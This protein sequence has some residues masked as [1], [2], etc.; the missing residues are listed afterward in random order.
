MIILNKKVEKKNN[1]IKLQSDSFCINK[2]KEFTILDLEQWDLFK[3]SKK[4]LSN[5]GIKVFS[6][7]TILPVIN[8]LILFKVIEINF[9]NFK[10]G[11]PF[12][13]VKELRRVHHFAGEIRASGNILPDQYTFLLRCGFDS[14]EIPEDQKDLWIE[15]L[16]IDD[17]F[18]YQP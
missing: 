15:L 7:Q 1:F 12:T 8:D 11:R 2:I 9:R 4:K 13:L 16:D 17:G 5:L 3:K 6:D 18:Y 14:V 10:D